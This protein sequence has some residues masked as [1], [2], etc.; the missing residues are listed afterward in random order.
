M[1]KVDKR[2]WIKFLSNL[3][4]VRATGATSQCLEY[5]LDFG[6]TLLPAVI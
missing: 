1:S 6:Q 4:S 5:P 2:F 3:A